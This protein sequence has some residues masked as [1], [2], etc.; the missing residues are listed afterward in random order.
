[1]SYDILSDFSLEEL[2]KIPLKNL[3]LTRYPWEPK[4]GAKDFR[5]YKKGEQVVA[6]VYYEYTY[7]ADKREIT[8]YTEHIEIYGASGEIVL[9]KVLD[10][11]VTPKKLK[12]INRDVRQGRIDYLES[13]AENEP[14]LAPYVGLL[15]K[16]YQD[17]IDDYVQ[18]AGLR[19]EKPYNP[20]GAHGSLCSRNYYS[21]IYLASTEGDIR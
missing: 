16:W 10:R 6:K 1:M 14:T 21:R 15:L 12:K 13:F 17:E 8:D 11:E 4:R 3:P 5:L 20:V 2:D 9:E 19:F 18:H 7:S